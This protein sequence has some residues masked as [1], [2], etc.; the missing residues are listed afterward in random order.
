MFSG[1]NRG[2]LYNGIHLPSPRLV[3][4]LLMAT[5]HITNDDLHTHMLMQWGQF[6]DHDLGLSP[7][8]ISFS[9]FSDGTRCN[10]TCENTNPCYP[11][12]VPNSDQRIQSHTCLGFTRSSSTC[13]TGSTSLFF[14]TVRANYFYNLQQL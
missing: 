2:K 10:E 11:I 7:Q 8:A 1:W 6:L 4:S 12:P 5:P 14:N 13:N 3:S 9:R